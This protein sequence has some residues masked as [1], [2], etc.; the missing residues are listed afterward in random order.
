MKRISGAARAAV[1]ALALVTVP[2]AAVPLAAE[3]STPNPAP[4]PGVVV[5]PRPAPTAVDGAKVA[6]APEPLG[7]HLPPLAPGQ[8]VASVAQPA[9]ASAYGPKIM[10]TGYPPKVMRP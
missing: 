5:D 9:T 2:L 4:T 10:S 6:I 7:A 8:K 3:A 1:V